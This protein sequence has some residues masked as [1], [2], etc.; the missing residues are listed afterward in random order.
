M[1]KHSAQMAVNELHKFRYMMYFTLLV[2][3]ISLGLGTS[4]AEDMSGQSMKGMDMKGMEPMDHQHM[5]MPPL[6]EKGHYTVV[7]KTYDVPDMRMVE[8]SGKELGLRNLLN[9]DEPVMLN[10]I[11]TTCTTLCPVMS[12]TFHDVQKKLGP[13][14]KDVRLVSVSI[15][16]ENDTPAELTKYAT[17][18]KAGSQ[19]TFLTGTVQQSVDVQMAFGIF[20]GEKMN[21]TPVT[22][23]KAK[24]ARSNWVRI[25][26]LASAGQII[27]EYDKLKAG[28]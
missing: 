19:W 22:F 21:H 20:A 3:L 14:R 24:G 9:G 13:G 5:S 1:R 2:S 28:K 8:A 11:F 6:P 17:K 16:P 7:S 18:F 15:D 26:G 25:D 10:F 4:H 12:A 23:I 27:K